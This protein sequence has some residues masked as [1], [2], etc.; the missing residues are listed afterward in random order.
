LSELQTKSLTEPKLRVSKVILKMSF[1]NIYG[2]FS[3]MV[4]YLFP[5]TQI[6]AATGK[7][8]DSG[9]DSWDHMLNE[10]GLSLIIYRMTLKRD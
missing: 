7:V 2:Q 3:E 10:V 4:A 8:W 6:Q 5:L 1:K 9:K